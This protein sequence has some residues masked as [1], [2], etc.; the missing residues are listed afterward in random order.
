VTEVALVHPTTGELLDRIETRPPEELAELLLAIRERR[1][2]LGIQERIVADELRRRVELRTGGQNRVVCF[3][4]FEVTAHDK[5]E[6]EWDP[7]ALET[8][9]RELI[10]ENVITAGSITGLIR[11]E[12]TVSRSEAAK[13]LR[14][15]GGDALSR[16]SHCFT[17]KR[18]PGKVEVVRSQPLIPEEGAAA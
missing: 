10:D 16:V 14:R 13:L 9:A 8:I 18:S 1:S 3:G 5:F 15:L 4:D 6:R 12:T 17:W 2:A 7:E 11:H